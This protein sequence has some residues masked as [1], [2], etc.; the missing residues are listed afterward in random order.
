MIDPLAELWR[1][2]RAGARAG[3][4][5][6]YQDAVATHLAFLGWT[7]DL[8]VQTVVP[9]G[10]EDISLLFADGWV[11]VQAKSRLSPRGDFGVAEVLAHLVEAWAK[12]EQRSSAQPG[13][14]LVLV[15]ERPVRGLPETGWVRP[16]AA[17]PELA[18]A[19]RSRLEQCLESQARA[20][21]LMAA[22]GVVV[23]AEP[24]ERD[25]VTLSERLELPP[26]ACQVHYH[27]VYAEIGRLSDENRTRRVD[28]PAQLVIG[29]VQR[30]LDESTALV[31]LDALEEAIRTGVCEVV[32]FATP[33]PDARFWEG[34]DVVPGH[35]VA[36][37]PVDRPELEEDVLGGLFS[38]RAALVVGP[39]GAGKSAAV[40]M[41]AYASR[42]LVRWYRVKRLGAADV[43]SL[44]RLVR[45]GRPS[46]RAP[47][48]LVVDD[49]GRGGRDG[50]DRLV[51]EAT[52]LPGVLLLGAVREEDLPLL[53][54]AYRCHRARP[55]LEEGLAERIWT[56]LK[57]SG[58]TAW[59]DWR[60]PFERSEGL[61]LEYG[62]L[63]TTGERLVETIA[64]QIE[65]RRQEARDLE[66][67]A[68]R[69]VAT[70]DAWGATVRAEAL[71]AALGVTEEDLQRALQRLLEEH[72][73]QEAEPGLLGGLH[74]VRSRHAVAAAHRIPPPT[75][76]ATIGAVVAAVDA[77]SLQRFVT[78][79][80]A[81]GA[82]P[83]DELLDHL[84]YRLRVE[85]NPRLLI[86]A[87]QA[88][89]LV[90]FRRLAADW[91]GILREEGVPPAQQVTAAMFAL[92]GISTEL[93]LSSIQA[94][95][96]RMAARSHDDLRGSLLD[97]LS[98]AEVR[99]IVDR[100]DRV[101]LAT[102]L[103]AALAEVNLPPQ[104]VASLRSLGR[105]MPEGRVDSLA[106]CLAAARVLD[107]ELARYLAK[108]AGGSDAV[109]ARIEQER[110]WVRGLKTV[111]DDQGRLVVEGMVRYVAPSVQP[112]V[113]EDVVD[114]CRL[115]LAC[116]PD[117]EVAACWA[118]DAAGEVAGYGGVSLANKHIA[119]ARLPGNA[120]VAWSRARLRTVA[121]LVAAGNMTERLVA[122]R[123]ILER[124]E[125]L[126]ADAA[127]YYCRGNRP[128]NLDRERRQLAAAVGFVP[129]PPSDAGEALGPLEQG[130]VEDVDPVTLLVVGI[131]ANMLR[132]LFDADAPQ[133]AV[134]TFIRDTLLQHADRLVDLSR[135]RLL[136]DPPQ[137]AVDGIRQSLGQLHPIAAERAVGGSE[138]TAEL[139]TRGGRA[140]L[141]RALVRCSKLARERADARLDA[142]CQRL[143]DKLLHAGY[144]ADAF[145]RVTSRPRGAVWPPDEIAVTVKVPT[146]LDWVPAQSAVVEASREVLEPARILVAVPVRDGQIVASLGGNVGSQFF[147][148]PDLLRGWES[149]LPMPFLNERAS[150]AT[151]RW[152]DALLEVSGIL[153]GATGEQLHHVERAVADA[154]AARFQAANAQ[155]AAMAENDLTGIIQDA[156]LEL[157]PLLGSVQDQVRAF[158]EGEAADARLAIA[159]ASL[160]RGEIAEEVQAFGLVRFA[161]I[162][163]DVEPTGA[164]ARI[165]AGLERL[166]SAS[167]GG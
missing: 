79:I 9:E 116:V 85:P 65:R 36:G 86:A 44:L 139:L 22:T 11:H 72:L 127:D 87:L 69:L 70:A 60:E 122:E 163:W 84:V 155:L 103:L 59:A 133:A 3:R 24:R 131:A 98:D 111:T 31:D 94:A 54:T 34:V 110:P 145:R 166:R 90:G 81:E 164:R 125:R 88:L 14:R 51:V 109:L 46:D 95:V 7:Q 134:A 23:V 151:R 2:G 118:V 56:E 50:W 66:L 119:R 123:S 55:G 138:A 71:R 38:R 63:L 121:A 58:A 141:S 157:Q 106:G 142:S 97:R 135:W 49:L 160:A 33:L 28:D 26:Q 48:G 53:E 17:V 115:V 67:R 64:S 5:F 29:D 132:R 13:A 43:E 112:D 73:I 30:R 105:L 120:E 99:A 146:V 80:G 62:H 102:E 39:S 152:L 129:P 41:A 82:I 161:L 40:W 153:G 154:A 35:V 144:R 15:L 130:E 92:T 74:Q 77:P 16:I 45:A 114:L 8:P 126:L 75:L 89:R 91:I 108:Q 167:N 143:E 52:Q 136:S 78:A 100:I 140:P 21:A 101:E 76:H 162:E 117:A 113:H 159:F 32:D 156:I 158:E 19:L 148:L 20:E 150:G 57:A 93:L 137:A 10:L 42:H 4:G 124:T 128:P 1:S 147:A 25:L 37:L 12:H 104:L 96:P 68:L 61:L 165:D 6:R 149:D 107:V 83:N 27:A 47:I 18:S